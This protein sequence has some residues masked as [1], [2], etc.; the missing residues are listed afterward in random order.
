MFFKKGQRSAPPG[1]AAAGV[2]PTWDLAL[3]AGQI[4]AL[5]PSLETRDIEP[6]L[7]Q[8][9]LA[10]HYR[11]LQLEPVPPHK[12]DF[13]VRQFDTEAWRRLALAVGTFDHAGLRSVLAVLAP[14]VPVMV[15]VGTGFIAL[16]AGT[17]ALTVALIRQSEVRVEEFARHLAAY[18]RIGWH[19][20]SAEQSK[21]RLAQLDYK[22]LLAE[23][24]EA[25][26]QAE[27]RM[28]QLRKKQEE[29]EARRRPRGKH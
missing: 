27:E 22:R 16:A 26:K 1:S 9:R 13:L 24:A 7:V 14:E 4:A 19:G 11:D 21:T 20:E 6:A 15:Q 3:V 29:A 18:L 10:D 28:D 5:A 25:K 23:A 12:F 2:G 17:D 8:A